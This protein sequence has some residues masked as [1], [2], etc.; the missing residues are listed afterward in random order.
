MD[1]LIKVIQKHSFKLILLFV[2]LGLI[3]WIWV[4]PAKYDGYQPDQP[5]PFS[6][7]IHAHED[8]N[9]MDCQFCHAGVETSAHATV[10]DAQTCMKCHEF[11]ATDSPDIQFLQAAYERG[12]PLRW[13]KVHDLPDHVRFS[14]M[15][16]V[17]AGLDCTAC[18]GDVASMEKVEVVTAFNMGWCVNCHRRSTEELS[19]Q[20][21][22][23]GHNETV[24]LTECSTCHY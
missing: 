6:H 15:P 10:P 21:L 3:Y 13:H 12:E 23:P 8:E 22:P 17:N 11:V 7:V 9:N 24:N 20:E 18:H 1:A 16:H 4:V 5:I 14:H 2:S 19:L